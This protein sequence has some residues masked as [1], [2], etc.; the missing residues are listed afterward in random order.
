MLQFSQ[1]QKQSF[2]VSDEDVSA[3]TP[4]PKTSPLLSVARSLSFVVTVAFFVCLFCGLIPSKRE[5]SALELNDNIL[6][7][8][9]A[10]IKSDYIDPKSGKT[11]LQLKLSHNKYL[12]LLS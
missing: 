1:K 4:F 9:S 3:M 10:G 2:K 8:I 5:V 7:L 12:I 11:V 6:S